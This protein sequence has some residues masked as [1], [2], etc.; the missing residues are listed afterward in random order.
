MLYFVTTA[1]CVRSRTRNRPACCSRTFVSFYATSASCTGAYNA[2]VCS[3]AFKLTSNS[4]SGVGFVV[5]VFFFFFSF[6][7]FVFVPITSRCIGDQ[8]DLQRYEAIDTDRAASLFGDASVR[9][10][11]FFVLFFWS[12]VCLRCDCCLPLG[13][14]LDFACDIQRQVEQ[15][16]HRLRHID[17]WLQRNCFSFPTNQSTCIC[18]CLFLFSL[19]GKH[20]RKSRSMAINSRSICFGCESSFYVSLNSVYF[21]STIR[22]PRRSSMM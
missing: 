20:E 1:T 7:L 4:I 13:L 9:S 6:F 10:L 22:A 11:R 15:S 12:N 19:V 16:R 2:F 17:H 3:F 18:S 21:S 5:V 14:L 8:L